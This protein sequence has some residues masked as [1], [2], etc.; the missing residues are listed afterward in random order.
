MFLLQ[1]WPFESTCLPSNVFCPKMSSL[2]LFSRTALEQAY[3]KLIVRMPYFQVSYAQHLFTMLKS[4]D[5][6]HFLLSKKSCLVWQ[7][8][9][10]GLH[11]VFAQDNLAG[12]KSL[13]RY[14]PILVLMLNSWNKTFVSLRQ[15]NHFHLGTVCDR[16]WALFCMR[17]MK[18][19]SVFVCKKCIWNF[20]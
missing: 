12:L 6:S 15:Q 20:G 16:I 17:S 2:H 19:A 9:V 14:L 8:G 7:F 4:K 11:L 13:P 3:D 1:S 10:L 18:P 5:R